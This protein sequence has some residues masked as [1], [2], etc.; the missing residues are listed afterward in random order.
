MV[1]MMRISAP[2][3]AVPVRVAFVAGPLAMI[4]ADLY[5]VH[6]TLLQ[7]FILFSAAFLVERTFYT[8][9]FASL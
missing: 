5:I 8:D 1:T 4:P 3:H 2:V 9:R 6:S 7:Y